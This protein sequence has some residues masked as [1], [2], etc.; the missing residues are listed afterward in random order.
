MKL[1]EQ[2]P[3]AADNHQQNS[4]Q[5]M[6][7]GKA[8]ALLDLMANSAGNPNS[9]TDEST[10]IWLQS[11]AKLATWG[12]LLAAERSERPPDS[13]RIAYLKQ[14]IADEEVRLR[15]TE[16]KLAEINLDFYRSIN[17]Q[18][19]VAN[20]RQISAQLPV[21]AAL[22]QYAYLG[23]ELLAW[24]INANGLIQASRSNVDAREL[25]RLV[26]AFQQACEHRG[27]QQSIGEQI[28]ELL[29][30]PLAT[31]INLHTRL[32]I[33]PYGTTHALP[34]HALPWQGKPLIAGHSVSYLP[35][36]SILQY[37][38]IVGKHH[39][40]LQSI[41]AVGNP[42]NM[43]YKAPFAESAIPQSALPAAGMEAAYVAG[44]FSGSRTLIG[45]DA[46]EAAVRQALPDFNVLHFATHGIL[47]ETAPMLSSIL[48][49]DGEMLTVQDLLGLRLNA[50]LV[51]LSACRTGQG[52]VAGGDD[53][54]GFSRGLLA[55][56]ASA[57]VVSL[58]PVDDL[59]T[60]LLMGEFYRRLK[61]G[62]APGLA[63]QAAQIHL[64]NLSP[65]AIKSERYVVLNS[66]GVSL[67][68][69]V[70]PMD[71]RHPY[72]WAP[73]VLIG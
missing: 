73:F 48:L 41:L 43:S 26:R 45:V 33:V 67:D 23:E 34:F 62:D 7:R 25:D 59:A 29:L 20:V 50:E 15:Q 61:S 72:Y 1:A 14:N 40:S 69:D 22:L 58:W 57:V 52:K 10:R 12:S 68:S 63:L 27:E 38:D 16:T 64:Q 32:L 39:K 35:S 8:R 21:D 60:S 49:A 11:N 19:P 2:E 65:D 54:L 44:L 31:T 9:V 37:L 4:Y 53:V 5:Y 28:S 17:R 70:A 6:E 24:A 51:V 18:A 71:Y 13:E 36:A 42:A 3:A 47:S 46:T 66:R 56:G 30:K 55:A